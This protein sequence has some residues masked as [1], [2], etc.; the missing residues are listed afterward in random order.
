MSNQTTVSDLFRRAME[1]RQSNPNGSF[2]D[3]KKNS[4]ANLTANRFRCPLF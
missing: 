4:S 2:K 3:V 1:I